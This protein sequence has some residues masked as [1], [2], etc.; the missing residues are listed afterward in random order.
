LALFAGTTKNEM[1]FHRGWLVLA[2]LEKVSHGSK[3]LGDSFYML[4]ENFMRHLFKE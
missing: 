3:K 1:I 2:L 4:Q